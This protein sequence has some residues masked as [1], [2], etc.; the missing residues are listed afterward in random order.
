MH[1]KL[2]WARWARPQYPWYVPGLG[3]S[4]V[5]M[6]GSTLRHM[7][8]LGV[9]AGL[10]EELWA[11]LCWATAPDGDYEN[12]GWGWARLVKAAI[13]LCTGWVWG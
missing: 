12:H 3:L 13:S 8:D 2:E 4:H 6:D 1:R 11:L 9:G 5:R 7:Q 10:V